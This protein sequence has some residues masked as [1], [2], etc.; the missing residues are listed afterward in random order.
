M[1]NALDVAWASRDDAAWQ[2]Y[3]PPSEKRPTSSDFIA[4][5]AEILRK[6]WE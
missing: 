3:F 5:M 2:Q 1:R 6:S 4:C